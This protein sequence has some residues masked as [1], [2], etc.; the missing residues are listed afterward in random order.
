MTEIIEGYSPPA[1]EK[2][3]EDPKDKK[4]LTI[5]II[6]LC[7]GTNNNTANIAEREKFETGVKAE[8]AAH[9]EFGKKESSYDNGRT[10]IAT[11]E[12][13]VKAGEGV[14]GYS[15]VVKVYVQGQGTFN[16]KKD[17][18]FFGKGMP[19]NPA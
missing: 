16:F 18:N 13:H 19:V 2:N 7:D 17:S 9:K 10:N 1:L 14:G 5:R 15:V 6:L 11:M 8:S 4:P 12:P 3:A